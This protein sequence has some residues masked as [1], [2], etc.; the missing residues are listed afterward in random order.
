MITTTGLSL[1]TIS[2]T[3][4]LESGDGYIYYIISN[5]ANKT[6]LVGSRIPLAP[7]LTGFWIHKNPWP[8]VKAS[9][10]SFGW[11]ELFHSCELLLHTE[12]PDQRILGKPWLPRGQVEAGGKFIVTSDLNPR[13]VE[14][15]MLITDTRGRKILELVIKAGFFLLWGWVI[16]NYQWHYLG[17]SCNFPCIISTPYSKLIIHVNRLPCSVL[18]P[19][20]V[21]C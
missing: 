13:G 1:R 16:R 21:V 3:N 10:G 11:R 5:I 19:G 17:D 7:Q 6:V 8:S 2:S 15:G 20:L 14:L 18:S 9:G 12:R 4:T